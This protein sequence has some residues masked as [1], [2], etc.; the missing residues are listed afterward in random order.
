M[1]F[2][3]SEDTEILFHHMIETP[4]THILQKI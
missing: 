2:R 1:T 3:N 4:L